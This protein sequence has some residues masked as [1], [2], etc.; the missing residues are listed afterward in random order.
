MFM[1]LARAFP[2]DPTGWWIFTGTLVLYVV[3]RWFF[4]WQRA[5]REGDG[6]PMRTAFAEEDPPDTAVAGGGF[7]SYR[8]F[9]GFVGSA[10]AVVLVA[11]LTAGR[12]RLA[13][14]WTIVPLLVTAL[15]YLDFRQARKARDSS[16]MRG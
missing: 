4:T 13:L 2:D 15:A 5:R 8:Q 9:F 3:A 11:A 7:R 6:N 16:A 14:L 10:V 12:L 1:T